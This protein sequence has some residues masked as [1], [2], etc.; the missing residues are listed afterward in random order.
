MAW[1]TNFKRYRY[2]VMGFLAGILIW[3]FG[4][5]LEFRIEKL[6]FQW[7]ALAYLHRIQPLII[8]FDLAPVVLGLIGWL[9]DRRVSEGISYFIPSVCAGATLSFTGFTDSIW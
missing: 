6:P 4:S 5:W 7:W 3:S 8:T 9:V 1:T 2:T